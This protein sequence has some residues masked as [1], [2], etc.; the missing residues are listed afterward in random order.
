MATIHKHSLRIE[1]VYICSV[2]ILG[3]LKTANWNKLIFT[4]G[5]FSK[6]RK[7]EKTRTFVLLVIGLAHLPPEKMME[8]LTWLR[9][10]A[11]SESGKTLLDFYEDYW[12]KRWGAEGVSVYGRKIVSTTI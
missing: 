6:Y 11:S 9:S 3:L 2:W 10:I 4:T 7:E 8:G 1:K 12:I 5:W